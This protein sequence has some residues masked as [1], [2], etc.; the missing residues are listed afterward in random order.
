MHGL[1]GHIFDY[2]SATGAIEIAAKTTAVYAFLVVGLRLLGKRELG[3]MSLYDVVM[4]IVLGNAV[5]NAMINADNT[6]GGGLL[7]AAVLL[8]LNRLLNEI[9][10][11]SRAAEHLLTGDPVL[12]VHDGQVLRDRMRREGLTDDQL[13]AALREHGLDD[14]T[15]VHLAVL[16]VDGSISIVPRDSTVMRTKRHYRGLRLP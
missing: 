11:R 16:E 10:L 14:P 4:I 13:L 6:L 2:P 15:E 7:A 3:Q 12:I 8:G 9:V 1:W 5:Q